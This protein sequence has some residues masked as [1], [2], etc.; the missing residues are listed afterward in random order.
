MLYL[1][2]AGSFLT[3]LPGAAPL[4]APFVWAAAWLSR[5]LLW[6]AQALSQWK[7]AFLSLS[8]S[9][10]LVAAGLLA[11]LIAWVLAGRDRPPAKTAGRVHGGFGG[12]RRGVPG[13]AG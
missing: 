11:L 8:G 13:V 6:M 3:L 9:G 5:L 1:A 12:V 4:A 7:G 2:F 10:L